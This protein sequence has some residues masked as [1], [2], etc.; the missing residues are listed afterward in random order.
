MTDEQLK[1][2]QP[3]PELVS[4][5]EWAEW[6]QHPTTQ[7]FRELLRKRLGERQD[8]WVNGNFVTLERNAK[9]IGEVQVLKAILELTSDEVNQGMNDE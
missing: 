1:S 9:A 3:Q 2:S 6:K 4:K 7:I 5:E 8:D